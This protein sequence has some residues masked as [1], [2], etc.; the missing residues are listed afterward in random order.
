MT[1][2][3]YCDVLRSAEA[4]RKASGLFISFFFSFFNFKISTGQCHESCMKEV[5]QVLRSIFNSTC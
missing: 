5:Q 3:K 4:V 1:K 2:G